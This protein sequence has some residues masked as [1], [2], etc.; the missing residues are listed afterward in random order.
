MIE[1]LRIE[2]FRVYIIKIFIKITL[3][4]FLFKGFNFDDLR[5]KLIKNQKEVETWKKI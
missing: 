2:Y 3:Q 4:F 5:V 1:F